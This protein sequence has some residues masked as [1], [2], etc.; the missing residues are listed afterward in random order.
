MQK[1]IKVLIIEDSEDDA[2]LL[3]G[4][5]QRGGYDPTYEIVDTPEVMAD[6]QLT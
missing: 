3:I 4:T 6:A 5:L 1:H 2:A